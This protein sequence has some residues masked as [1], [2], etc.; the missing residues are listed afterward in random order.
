[1]WHMYKTAAR[2]LA[3]LFAYSARPSPCI[4][5]FRM[6]PSYLSISATHAHDCADSERLTR[7]HRNNP[8]TSVANAAFL[9]ADYTSAPHFCSAVAT[10]L[11]LS[12]ASAKTHLFYGDAM[13]DLLPLSSVRQ[14]LNRFCDDRV[15]FWSLNA[16]YVHFR[17]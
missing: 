14:R 16:Y 5:P 9:Q 10:V 2:R 15:P 12:S 7:V 17:K 1:M 6:F 8:I 4:V 11:F 13:S 3:S